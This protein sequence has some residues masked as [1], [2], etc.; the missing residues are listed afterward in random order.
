MQILLFCGH[1]ILIL[2]E[3]LAF[4]QPFVHLCGYM[5]TGMFLLHL[6][7]S[8][9]KNSNQQRTLFSV[10]A[11]LLLSIAKIAKIYANTL[12]ETL[13]FPTPV[14]PFMPDRCPVKWARAGTG[15]EGFFEMV[16]CLFFYYS[17]WI[18]T[19]YI[20]ANP[21]VPGS[22]VLLCVHVWMIAVYNWKPC[23]LIWGVHALLGGLSVGRGTVCSD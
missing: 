4:C 6:S 11:M 3:R 13:S 7:C 21:Q 20:C 12:V 5:C 10:A 1:T 18:F 9:W 15:A 14:W 16:V 23:F 8:L 22:S 19:C 17:P 2:K